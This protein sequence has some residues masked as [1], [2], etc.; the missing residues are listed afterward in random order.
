MLLEMTGNWYLNN[1]I[2]LDNTLITQLVS[3]LKD[4]YRW[5]DD[6]E[7]FLRDYKKET[8]EYHESLISKFF[9]TNQS[10]DVQKEE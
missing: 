5:C 3:R 10:D 1:N 4:Y 6:N 9:S 8:R 7:L 2:K